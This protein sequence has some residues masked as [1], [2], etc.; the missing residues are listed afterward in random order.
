MS[1]K[2]RKEV[3]QRQLERAVNSQNGIRSRKY[4]EMS[5]N[6]VLGDKEIAH[7]REMYGQVIQEFPDLNVRA[8]DCVS[9]ELP[10]RRDYDLVR[11]NYQS[12]SQ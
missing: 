11:Q 4:K 3:K 6:G 8:P 5:M 1:K 10:T 12:M 9:G 7:Y 2:H